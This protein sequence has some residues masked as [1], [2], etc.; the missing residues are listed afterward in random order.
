MLF[1]KKAIQNTCPLK[2]DGNWCGANHSLCATTLEYDCHCFHEAF[3]LG[4]KAAKTQA[5]ERLALMEFTKTLGACEAKM[6]AV[7]DPRKTSVDEVC[8]WIS[9]HGDNNANPN[10]MIVDKEQYDNLVGGIFHE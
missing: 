6:Y 10:I 5:N 4:K 2:H 8:E 1:S 7:F 3:E 9:H